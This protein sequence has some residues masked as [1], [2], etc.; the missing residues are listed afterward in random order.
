M[1]ANEYFLVENR[2]LIGFDSYL[3]GDGLAIYHVDNNVSGNN[4]QWYPGYTRYGHYQVALEQADGFWGLDRGTSTG[5]ANDLWPGYDVDKHDFNRESTPNSDCYDRTKTRVGV[6]QI[7]DSSWFMIAD[8]FVTDAPDYIVGGVNHN[9]SSELLAGYTFS[10]GWTVTNQGSADADNST[11]T[12]LWLSTDTSLD[13]SDT[14]L[15]VDAGEATTAPLTVGATDTKAD[16]TVRIPVDIATGTYYLLAKADDEDIL[17]E[18]K[19]QNNVGYALGT[20]QVR[21]LPDYLFTEMGRYDAVDKHLGEAFEAYWSVWN[22]GKELG[23]ESSVISFYLSADTSLDD[24]DTKITDFPLPVMLAGAYDSESHIFLTVPGGMATGTYY[25]IAAA[26]ATGVISEAYEDNNIVIGPQVTIV[27][28]SLPEAPTNISPTA[29]ATGEMINPTLTATAYS[30]SQTWLSHYASQW[31]VSTDA[32]DFSGAYLAWDSGTDTVNLTSITVPIG[33]LLADTTYWWRVRYQ[34]NGGDW[35]NY[36]SPTSFTTADDVLSV[37]ASADPNAIASG[38][39]T[40]LT[41]VLNDNAGHPATIWNWTDNGAGG[42]FLPS[43]AVANPTWTGP[44]NS[45]VSAASRTLSVTITCIGGSS[46]SADVSVTE[47]SSHTISVSAAALP[48]TIEPMG[49][50]NLTAT[51]SDN[52]GHGTAIWSWSDNG[53]GGTFTPN[54]NVQSPVWTPPLNN[55]G[56]TITAMLSVTATCN[57]LPAITDSDTISISVDSLPIDVI[58][59]PSAGYYMF[60]LPVINPDR[61]GGQMTLRECISNPSAVVTYT[62]PNG[63]STY[64]V[65]TWSSS[66]QAFVRG[67]LDDLLNPGQAYLI[68]VSSPCWIMVTGLPYT[69]NRDIRLGWNLIGGPSEAVT[70]DEALGRVKLTSGLFTWDGSVPEMRNATVLESGMGYWGYA[71]VVGTLGY[72]KTTGSNTQSGK[73]PPTTTPVFTKFID[74]SASHWAYSAISEL[75]WLGITGGIANDG[76]PGKL[77]RTSS[78]PTFKPTGTLTRAQLAMYLVRAFNLQLPAAPIAQFSDVSITSWA[79]MY[80]EAAYQAGA[81]GAYG[82]NPTRF[83]P[84]TLVTRGQFAIALARAANLPLSDNPQI[85][86]SDVNPTTAGAAEIEALYFLGVFEGDPNITGL[87]RPNATLTRAEMAY[88]LANT[89]N[90][91]LEE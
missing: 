14:R 5:D 71:S 24:S 60:S 66:A 2:Q 57:G 9:V 72:A 17:G 65:L 46:A 55:T 73:L 83:N 38:G 19:E 3:P 89:L 79:N 34:S 49:S 33:N 81:M 45:S 31:Q 75:R 76:A 77:A 82:S 56:A 16:I 42:T 26:D 47:Q 6:Q 32:N 44:G 36:S 62:D 70:L 25:L 22:R 13:A 63:G 7:S 51:V 35:S 67:K 8:L 20:I 54:A 21:G 15:E 64:E 88:L 84:G 40:Q 74:V 18:S 68:Q 61:P 53:A 39:T 43:A 59:F 86:Y 27:A 29:G 52:W 48:T 4:N 80:V 12:S 41:S 37:I 11:L 50:T 10:T 91:T 69:L 90:V 78:T 30:D 23:S 28:N 87:F 85:I 58:D 1:P